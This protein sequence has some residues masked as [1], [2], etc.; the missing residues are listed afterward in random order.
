M[1]YEGASYDAKGNPLLKSPASVKF[2]EDG[3]I[4]IS[5]MRQLLDDDGFSEEEK[6]ALKQL[7]VFF[8]RNALDHLDGSLTEEDIIFRDSVYVARIKDEE[9]RSLKRSLLRLS[10]L[11]LKNSHPFVSFLVE[12]RKFLRSNDVMSTGLS[13]ASLPKKI[14][15]RIRGLGVYDDTFVNIIRPKMRDLFRRFQEDPD[16]DLSS[17]VM[18]SFTMRSLSIGQVVLKFLSFLHR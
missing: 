18:P 14:Q 6:H 7:R 16:A 5:I 10:K 2:D 13:K 11:Y 8:L 1:V 15:K 12:S 9:W 17:A 3:R 4:E